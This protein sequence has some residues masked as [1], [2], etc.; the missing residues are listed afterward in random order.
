[1]EV[2]TLYGQLEGSIKMNKKQ[3]I[4]KYEE[5]GYILLL[6]GIVIGAGC[7]ETAEIYDQL[8]KDLCSVAG[9]RY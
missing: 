6:H 2:K 5:D 4:E 3:F 7:S 9:V 1:M 8:F